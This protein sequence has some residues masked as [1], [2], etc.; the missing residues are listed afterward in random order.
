MVVACGSTVDLSE[1]RRYRAAAPV[2]PGWTFDGCRLDECL[3]LAER[4]TEA[5]EA[6][7]STDTLADFYETCG[8]LTAPE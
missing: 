4:V 1:C 2:P 6:G 8:D 3:D 7:C 5:C